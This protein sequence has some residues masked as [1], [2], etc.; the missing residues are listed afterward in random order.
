MASGIG[1]ATA[2]LFVQSGAKVAMHAIAD[3]N[4]ER[5]ER[6]SKTLGTE[7]L[8]MPTLLNSVHCLMRSKELMAN[9]SVKLNLGAIENIVEYRIVLSIFLRKSPYDYR[10]LKLGRT[11]NPHGLS[12]RYR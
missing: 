12:N 6:A 2:Q 10:T 8:S 9:L 4:Q 3:Q 1:F 5:L 11:R 7:V